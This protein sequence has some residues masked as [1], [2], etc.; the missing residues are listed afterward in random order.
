MLNIFPDTVMRIT[1]NNKNCLNG[2]VPASIHLRYEYNVVSLETVLQ[3]EK[4]R[5]IY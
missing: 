4:N 5:L 1:Q 2:V 3:R